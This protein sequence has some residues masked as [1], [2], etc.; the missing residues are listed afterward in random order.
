LQ[1]SITY[2][3]GFPQGQNVLKSQQASKETRDHPRSPARFLVRSYG[4][5]NAKSSFTQS[6][7]DCTPANQWQIGRSYQ[8]RFVY[9][10][11]YPILTMSLSHLL[12]RIKS[13]FCEL[14]VENMEIIV[15]I[16]Q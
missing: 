6:I 3:S 12:K 1:E 8:L 15:H 7:S 11:Q 13:R 9:F 14:F 4:V 5:T 16:V 2:P 10:A